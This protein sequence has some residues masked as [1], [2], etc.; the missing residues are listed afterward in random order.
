MTR[1][2]PR[3][4][5]DAAAVS[6]A[7]AAA[8]LLTAAGSTLVFAES[9]ATSR[10]LG[11]TPDTGLFLSVLSF[12]IGG[13]LFAVVGYLAGARWSVDREFALRR[14]VPSTTRV[15]LV[16]A[17]GDLVWLMG[18]LLLVHVV[19]Y[20]RSVTLGASDLLSAWPL[21][22][23]GA[24][25]ATSCYL[26]A[27]A[28]G[29]VLR[30]PFGVVLVAPAPYAATLL[31]GEL[32]MSSRPE[33]QQLVAPFVDQTWFPNLVPDPR[34][35]LVLAAYCLAVAVTASM[36]LV[37]VLGVRLHVA[38][39]RAAT[40]LVPAAGV[41]A[42]AALVASAWTP[43]GFARVDPAGAVCSVDDRVCVWTG[44]RARLPVLAAAER[45]V[46]TA[47][48]RAGVAPD[49]RFA[50]YGLAT[51]VTTVT[52]ETSPAHVDEAEVRR[53]MAA[54]YAQRW[55][56]PCVDDTDGL[57]V[58]ADL[59]DTLLRAVDAGSSDDLRP[60]VQRARAC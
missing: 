51:G 11:A 28:V 33:V 45:E 23:L 55:A 6:R 41:V 36:V 60:L 58:L 26:V 35:L 30:T 18:A 52:V 19:A 48:E 4:V 54:A 40:I 57:Q 53:Q 14:S 10:W 49:L 20:A 1:N 8:L 59:E 43:N 29:A 34:P 21:T 56:A 9:P 39:P 17:G 12:A 46:R 3:E 5:L 7:P 15:V 25:A 2:P 32:A 37:M 31:A 50:Q 24:A 22:L 13:C 16:A 42:S 44:S 47:V 27:A 38:R